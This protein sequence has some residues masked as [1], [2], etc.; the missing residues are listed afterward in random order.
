MM[1]ENRKQLSTGDLNTELS[2]LIKLEKQNELIILSITQDFSELI[3][4]ICC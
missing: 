3:T 1:M 2:E 4:L